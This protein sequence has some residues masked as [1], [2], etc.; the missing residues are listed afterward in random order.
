MHD[1]SLSTQQALDEQHP[2]LRGMPLSELLDLGIFDAPI[3]Q[4]H[5]LLL[6]PQPLL[7]FSLQHGPNMPR[8]RSCKLTPDE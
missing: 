1:E 7:L 8:L 5:L 2:D 3:F 6:L 4:Q